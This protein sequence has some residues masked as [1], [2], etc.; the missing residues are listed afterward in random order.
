MA[1]MNKGQR[2]N[3]E[4]RKPKKPHPVNPPGLPP[5]LA[6]LADTHPR[7]KKRAA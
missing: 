6:P 3:K 1:Q 7:P 2:G 5:G 4:A